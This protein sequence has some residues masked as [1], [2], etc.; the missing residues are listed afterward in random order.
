VTNQSIELE[1]EHAHVESYW[2]TVLRRPDGAVDL[3]GGR[4]VDRFERREDSW[5]IAFRKSV[6]EWACQAS[7]Y[8][9]A[10]PDVDLRAITWDRSDLSYL[11]PL[12]PSMF[13]YS[14]TAAG[15]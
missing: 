10:F 1:D 8:P 6:L 3:S 7:D 2:L 14:P 11:R 13:S 9:A 5:R 4:Y 15:L 12:Q